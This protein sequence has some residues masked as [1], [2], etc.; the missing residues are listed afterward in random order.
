MAKEEECR[1]CTKCKIGSYGSLKCSF[2]GRQPEFNDSSCQKFTQ[3]DTPIGVKQVKYVAEESP[4]EVKQELL[5]NEQVEPDGQVCYHGSF[6]GDVY[7]VEDKPQK[8]KKEKSLTGPL[9][10]GFIMTILLNILN[11]SKYLTTAGV[12]F[13]SL[14]FFVFIVYFAYIFVFY[15]MW[16]KAKP[17]RE[18]LQ[19]LYRSLIKINTGTILDRLVLFQSVFFIFLA[20]SLYH[21]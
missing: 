15:R 20:Q 12:I 11:T 14:S 21:R 2:Y 8:V 3:R 13:F 5:V 16:K 6:A 19:P 7:P 1:Q 17:N 4:K 18:Q 9:F 10:I